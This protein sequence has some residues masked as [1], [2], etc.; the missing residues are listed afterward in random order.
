ML[1]AIG[2]LIACMAVVAFFWA[3]VMFPTFAI[4]LF[5]VGVA[6]ATFGILAFCFAKVDRTR[7]AK[8]ISRKRRALGYDE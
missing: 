1:S 3:L 5:A 4:S 7:I 8:E 6:I 2:T